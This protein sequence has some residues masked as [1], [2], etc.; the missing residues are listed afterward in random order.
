MDKNTQPPTKP[1]TL[2][3]LQAS[4]NGALAAEQQHVEELA[5]LLG[6]DRAQLSALHAVMAWAVL[7]R[8]STSADDREHLRTYLDVMGFLPTDRKILASAER[9]HDIID[10]AVPVLQEE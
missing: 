5:A 10:A 8:S 9:S 2:F 6:L 4:A 3:A 1:I 7:L